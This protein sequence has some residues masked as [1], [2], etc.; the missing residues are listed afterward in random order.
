M[1]EHKTPTFL[2]T[3]LL[4][5]VGHTKFLKQFY[6][7]EGLANTLI[8]NALQKRILLIFQPFDYQA[9]TTIPPGTP[10]ILLIYWALHSIQN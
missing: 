7:R 2:F 4:L 5:L 3:K 10:S 1:V 8:F 6:F 9:V